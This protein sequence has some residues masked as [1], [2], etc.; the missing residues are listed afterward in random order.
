[1]AHGTSLAKSTST[2]TNLQTSLARS[3]STNSIPPHTPSNP[4]PHRHYSYDHGASRHTF[5]RSNRSKYN[6]RSS[7]FSHST[8]GSPPDSPDLTRS[9]SEDVFVF[10]KT[11]YGTRTYQ[12]V[13]ALD[14]GQEH[15]SSWT[16]Y[17]ARKAVVRFRTRRSAKGRTRY[18]SPYTPPSKLVRKVL[19]NQYDIARREDTRM[20]DKIMAVFYCWYFGWIS[21]V[22]SIFSTNEN[23]YAFIKW[24]LSCLLVTGA[25]QLV[26]VLLTA[27]LFFILQFV[28]SVLEASL[29]FGLT[30]A[31]VFVCMLGAV[32]IINYD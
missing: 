2:D 10:E 15:E 9:H 16:E 6:R 4:R 17:T 25:T 23:H 30:V 18:S 21:D 13:H 3:S 31:A 12:N 24:T 11:N 32:A 5:P 7:A 28:M 22:Y 19:H 26:L 29:W 8:P 20:V 1:M 27:L 14:H